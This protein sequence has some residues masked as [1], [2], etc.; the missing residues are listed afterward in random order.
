MSIYAGLKGTAKE[1]NLEGKHYWAM[2]TKEGVEGNVI[3]T[4][5]L[6]R[7]KTL[8]YISQGYWSEYADEIYM[9]VNCSF[10]P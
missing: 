9:Y 6:P 7:I 1:L 3:R 2:W 4:I 8:K 10:F 5:L